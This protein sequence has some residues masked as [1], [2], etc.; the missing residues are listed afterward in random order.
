M[1]CPTCDHT[2]EFICRQTEVLR[3]FQCPRCG[4]MVAEYNDG[5]RN[6]YVPKLVERCR[7]FEN[8]FPKENIAQY[9]RNTWKRL[10]ISESIHTPEERGTK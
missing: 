1:T 10:G 2:M 7:E 8:E 4:T 5:H 3:H 6:V 9:Y